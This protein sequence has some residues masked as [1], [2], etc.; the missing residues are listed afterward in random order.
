MTFNELDLKPSIL[1]ALEEMEIFNP[2]EIQ[3]KSI[4]LLLSNNTDFVGQ[5]QTGTGKTA[6]FVIPVLQKLDSKSKHVQ[7]LVMAPTR[8]LAQQVEAE[9]K[10]IGKYVGARS[11]CIYGGARYDKQIREIKRD[12][13]HIIV[14]TPGRLIDLVEKGILDLRNVKTCILDE[15][16]EMLRMGFIDDV[17][18]ILN[19]LHDERRLVMFSATLP[20]EISNLIEKNF[21]EHEV[22]RTKAKKVSNDLV[23][24]QYVV[25]KEKYIT[26]ALARL[27]AQE[28]EIY[29]MIF[30]KTKVDTKFV[31]DDLVARGMKVEILN[32]DMGQAQRDHAMR[33]FKEKKA[34]VLVC[35]D[36][37]ARGI[38]VNDLTHVFNMGMPQ[39][40]ESYVHR[41]GRTGRAGKT[42]IALT[43]VPKR[44]ERWLQKIAKDTKSTLTKVSLP[45]IDVL[46]QSAV[47]REIEKVQDLLGTIRSKGDDFAVDEVFE[48]FENEVKDLSKES[49]LKF[50]FTWRFNKEMRRLNSLPEIEDN[51]DHETYDRRRRRSRGRRDGGGFRSE[52][53]GGD[54]DRR[55]RG[56]RDRGDRRDRRDRRDRDGGE[57]G[58]RRSR[59]FR[60]NERPSGERRSRRSNDQRRS[61]DQRRRRS[62]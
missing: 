15:A 19:L 3:E 25:V 41:I 49:L 58:E 43:I 13:P 23:Q 52:R 40:R 61:G 10:K 12:N 48:A 24:Q 62:Y 17:E 53:S 26:E 57:R 37:A 18:T 2:T 5:A 60:S 44:D 34:N 8:E 56:D 36:V 1:R 7:V 30:C 38:D 20:R 46:K 55:S 54:R 16:D 11:V 31:G 35:T 22:V 9:V 27:I 28:E 21:G 29:T 42:G 39:C 32:G 33:A 47:Q 59:N 45:K 51:S 50:M 14:G 4:P 6:A